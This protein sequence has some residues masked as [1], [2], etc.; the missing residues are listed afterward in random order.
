MSAFDTMLWNMIQP[1]LGQWRTLM[2]NLSDLLMWQLIIIKCK[3]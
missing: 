1:K 2:T 3:C